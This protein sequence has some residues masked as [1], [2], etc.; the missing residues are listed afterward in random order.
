MSARWLSLLS[1]TMRDFFT[2]THTHTLQSSGKFFP[3]SFPSALVL[4]LSLS[5]SL[6]L[7]TESRFTLQLHRAIVFLIN[8][9]VPRKWQKVVNISITVSP[10]WCLHRSNF[11]RPLRCSV[12]HLRGKN[13]DGQQRILGYKLEEVIFSFLFRC[14]LSEMF[15]LE[16]REEETQKKNITLMSW[17]QIDNIL[18]CILKNLKDEFIIWISCR[19]VWGSFKGYEPVSV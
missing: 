5:L 18:K 4:S 12:N 15:R 7:F 14:K 3:L 1:F 19:S 8:H 11:I 6:S 9:V 10:R 13:E 2:H 17:N 16:W